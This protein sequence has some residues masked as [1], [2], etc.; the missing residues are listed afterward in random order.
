MLR[1]VS[2]EKGHERP[3]GG[4][5]SVERRY[6]APLERLAEPPERV[7]EVR[8]APAAR[9]GAA[10]E[11][12]HRSRSRQALRGGSRAGFPFR[13]GDR[14][15]EHEP[16]AA[17]A[18][19]PGP[20]AEGSPRAPPRTGARWRAPARIRGCASKRRRRRCAPG[21]PR[22]PRVHRP[23]S[24]SG[25]GGLP[26]EPARGPRSFLAR[27]HPSSG[28]RSPSAST[29]FRSRFSHDA[30]HDFRVGVDPGRRCRSAQPHPGS[31]PRTKV[32]TGRLPHQ[33]SRV[34]FFQPER[35]AHGGE[36]GR[37]APQPFHLPEDV[38]D[39]LV[40]FPFPF[41]GAGLAVRG[42]SAGWCPP[43]SRSGRA[44]S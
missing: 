33:R 27:A 5:E 13:A 16:Q 7:V 32:R 44:R 1:L 20:G 10:A 23:R 6:L 38:P 29:A 30:R 17:A 37:D 4:E 40:H 3:T 11:R 31:D 25:D 14:Q 22:R 21:A 28:G 18:V 43:R 41:P 35:S 39:A 24:R 9:A 2:P 8:R 34:H 19:L 26:R 15:V 36:L 12:Q 42:G